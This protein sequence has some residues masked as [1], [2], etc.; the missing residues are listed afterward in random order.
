MGRDRPR[1]KHKNLRVKVQNDVLC[2]STHIYKLEVCL[3]TNDKRACL[4]RLHKTTT[5][6]DVFYLKKLLFHDDK[7]GYS[8]QA[9]SQKF[10]LGVLH[11]SVSILKT[12]NV[13]PTFV[14]SLILLAII[15]FF[16][17]KVTAQKLIILFYVF[18]FKTRSSLNTVDIREKSGIILE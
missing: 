1:S 14:S 15:F 18:Y 5:L 3:S 2:T 12:Q 7:N 16:K 4:V 13:T 6:Y 10:A 9:H 17:Q 11:W 8:I